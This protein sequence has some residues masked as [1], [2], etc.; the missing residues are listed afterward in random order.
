MAIFENITENDFGEM[1]NLII[2]LFDL[3]HISRPSQQQLTELL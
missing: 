3:C 1:T 2:L